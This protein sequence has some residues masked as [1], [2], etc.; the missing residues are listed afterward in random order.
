MLFQSQPAGTMTDNSASRHSFTHLIVK[1]LLH[2]VAASFNCRPGLR[3]YLKSDDGWINF[4]IGIRTE[5]RSIEVALRFKDGRVSVMKSISDACDVTLIF[6]SDRAARELL[7]AT[8]TEQIFMIMESKFRF[9]GNASYMNLF[10]FYLSLLLVNKQKKMMQK[11]HGKNR[12]IVVGTGETARIIVERM[13]NA[14]EEFGC[15]VVGIVDDRTELSA[16]QQIFGIPFLG[17]IDDLPSLI[18]RENIG[19]VFL[20]KP[21]MKHERI[22]NLV[23]ACDDSSASFRIVSDLFEIM[24]GKAN[25]DNVADIPIID[26]T[27]PKEDRI[28]RL[29]K[30]LMD[31][32]LS[33]LFLAVSLPIWAIA[34]IAIKLD[35]KGSILFRQTRIGEHGA[36]FTIYKFRTMF[37]NTQKKRLKQISKPDSLYTQHQ[38]E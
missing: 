15:Q 38:N 30:R 36:E 9:V 33:T 24:T 4:E 1:T 23:A 17:Q 7:G 14:A 13:K 18:K 29:S 28:R 22:L 26:L 21:D 34:S 32:S 3:K 10:F 20:A 12:V 6:S 37:S 8:P 27:S 16:K 2:V 25:I 31:L 35:S 11:E 5:T 19:E